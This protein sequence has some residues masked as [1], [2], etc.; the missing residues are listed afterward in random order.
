[1]SLTTAEIKTVTEELSPL[2]SGGKI[3]RIDQ[4][5]MWRVIFHI[6]N[7][8]KRYWLQM[9]ADPRF[10][11]LHLLTGRPPT[12]GATTG[13]CNV[14]RQHLTGSPIER[15]TR[16]A[17]DRVVALHCVERDALLKK[18]TVRLIA[19]LV[20][21]GS[22]LVLVDEHNTVLG[23]FF[24]EDSS[25]R[26]LVAGIPYDPL[27][28]PPASERAKKNRFRAYAESPDVLSLS[29]SIMEHY[30]EAEEQAAFGKKYK[31][32][33]KYI[34]D[35]QDKLESL[36]HN[37][38]GDLKDAES[39]ERLRQDGELLKIALSDMIKG[40]ESVTVKDYF[41]RNTPLRRI[42]LDRQL[43][44]EENVQRLFSRYKQLKK[45]RIPLRRKLS[46]IDRQA[47]ELE[48]LRNSLDNIKTLKE[49]R[50]FESSAEIKQVFHAHR[51]ASEKKHD[52]VGSNGPRRF[53]SEHGFEILVARSQEESHRLTF[54]IA[55]GNDCWM[56][57][58]GI[59]GPHVIIRRPGEAEIPDGTLLDAAHLAVYYSKARGS[60][61][62]RVVHTLRKHVKPARGAGRGAVHYSRE[63]TIGV[64]PGKKRLRAVLERARQC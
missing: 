10:S 54:S 57:L 59:S 3:V 15:L 16:A 53:Y 55:R 7:R 41:C 45:S 40:Q 52:V 24:P 12:G 9:V 35:R 48:K 29:R 28:P 64:R 8:S 50:D 22:N 21:K 20:G 62:V 39:A 6:R 51:S 23:A 36:R 18:R 56:H 5:D 44:P 63:S 17:G 13:L 37:I 32:L 4:P 11:R 47:N 25:R 49:L 33:F 60:D 14:L 38:E 30:E 46:D 31:E 34:T 2:L 42:R 26:R 27:P 19:E 43:S 61:F 1:M 58:L